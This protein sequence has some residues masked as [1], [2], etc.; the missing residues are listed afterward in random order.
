VIRA[1][2]VGQHPRVKR[3]TLRPTLSKPVPGPVQRLGI[4]GIDHDAMV[5][6]E[7]HHPP[8]RPL[9]RRPPLDALRAPLVQL[10]APL[11]EARR[12]MRHGA[13]GDLRPALIHDPDGMRL[14]RPIDAHVV[15]HSST[16]FGALH[17]EPRSG[18]GQVGLIPALRGATFS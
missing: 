8:V 9:D 16:S 2:E 4:H 14:I 10:P 6:Q 11:A 17:A 12:R 1:Q 3:V 5:E 7:V 15:A 13:P 18:N